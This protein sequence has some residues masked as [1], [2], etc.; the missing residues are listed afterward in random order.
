MLRTSKLILFF[1]ALLICGTSNAQFQAGEQQDVPTITG[2]EQPVVTDDG[3]ESGAEGGELIGGD[4]QTE[5]QTL[6]WNQISLD[7]R[8]P[9]AYDYLRQA[10][11][12]WHKIIWRV[13]D[14]R[15]K[16][17]RPLVAPK[18][19]LISVIMDAAIAGTVTLYDGLDDEFTIPVDLNSIP[20]LSS[21]S[22]S[23][24]VYNPATDMDELTVITNDFNPETVNKFRIKEVWYFNEE[25][26]T[27]ENRILGIAPIMEKYGEFG[28][29]QGDV[30][31]FWASFPELRATLVKSE[32]YNPFPNGIKLTFDD[33]FAMRL[34]SSYIM[35]Q[36]NVEDLRIQDYT[37]GINALYESERITEELF[38]FEH[39]L[40]S[41]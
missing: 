33:L 22:D 25:T 36:D 3:G 35:K 20:A 28:N 19:P 7:E 6:P 14:C 41:Y 9:L 34:F 40:W 4:I 8:A 17:N 13:L 29:Y 37:T 5:V 32:A 16:M 31:L 1:A 27:M 21:Q 26:S 12:F 11:I 2:E 23:I 18:S 38:N 10:D 24:Y 39:D 15:E 30:P